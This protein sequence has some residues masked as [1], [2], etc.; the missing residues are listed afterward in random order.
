MFT[1]SDL[2]ITRE[3]E[4]VQHTL[5]KNLGVMIRQFHWVNLGINLKLLNTIC[6]R[7]YALN[8]WSSRKKTK[9]AL[10]QRGVA[11]HLGLKRFSGYPKYF[12][13]HCVCQELNSRA[14]E[15]FLNIQCGKAYLRVTKS[16]SLRMI[17]L[18]TYMTRS[19][20]IK[21]NFDR[22]F[23]DVYG[24]GDVWKNDFDGLISRA[25]YIQA[26]E[27]ASWFLGF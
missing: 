4:R 1:G 19:S 17:G 13:N 22:I 26:R 16:E 2:P 10:K 8:L 9:G 5:N 18:N 3:V 11:Y 7:M 23:S 27:E 6:L 21:W 14:F 15:H 20:S 12:S 25:F 24:I